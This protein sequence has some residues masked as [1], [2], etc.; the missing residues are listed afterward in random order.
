MIRLVFACA[1][2]WLAAASTAS[3]LTVCHDF[4]LYKVTGSDGDNRGRD[5]MITQLRSR[6]YRPI[7]SA[8]ASDTNALAKAQKYLRPGD[9][10]VLGTG[11]GHSGFM[12][13]SGI[14]HFIQ[15]PGEVGLR[16]DP[17]KLPRGPVR[18]ANANSPAFGGH[19]VGDS[20]AQ[21]IGRL[22]GRGPQ[23]I[24]IWSKINDLKVTIT[25][26]TRTDVDLWVAEPSGVKCW[27]QN[28]KTTNGGHLLEDNTVGFGPEHY[29]LARAVAGNFTIKVNYFSGPRNG[30]VEPT[31]VTIVVTQFEGTP[32]ARPQ[33][34]H[35]T[36][37]NRGETV[38]VHTVRFEER[39]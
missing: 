38:A 7:L 36:L 18:A 24:E 11:D 19:F 10:I 13:P 15:I 34:F 39:R 14:E 2:T 37:H 6:Q 4:T 32:N 23:P 12:T 26:D 5:E 22:S 8:N 31:A 3:A 27:Y 33:T 20:L 35:A 25:W 30:R 1:L 16:R 9:V 21:M 28:R 17:T 29:L